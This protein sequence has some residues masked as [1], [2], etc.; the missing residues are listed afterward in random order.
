M[1]R[2]KLFVFYQLMAFRSLIVP[3]DGVEM[4][5]LASFAASGRDTASAVE[6]IFRHRKAPKE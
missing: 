5:N 1:D 3:R 6:R 2:F 4:I